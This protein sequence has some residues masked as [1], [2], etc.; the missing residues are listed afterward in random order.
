MG[1]VSHATVNEERCGLYKLQEIAPML[2]DT[3]NTTQRLEETQSW[4]SCRAERCNGLV[5]GPAELH[6]RNF[7]KIIKM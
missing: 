2:N 7:C 5:G 3:A 1:V 6:D 4:V